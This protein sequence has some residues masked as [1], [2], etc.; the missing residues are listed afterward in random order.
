MFPYFLLISLLSSGILNSR[1]SQMCGRLY[2]PIFLLSVGLFTLNIDG[3]FNCSGQA[4]VLPSYYLEVIYWCCMATGTL[5]LEYWGWGLQMFFISF[6]KRSSWLPYIFLPTV[7]TSTGVAINNTVLVGDFFFIFWW[8][9]DVFK[10]P[11]SLKMHVYSMSSTNLLQAFPHT[12][13]IWYYYMALGVMCTSWG[14]LFLFI[15]VFL[16]YLLY[17]LICSTTSE[18]YQCSKTSVQYRQ[19][20]SLPTYAQ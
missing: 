4:I 16:K 1:L 2:F 19:L 6:S 8:H 20:T 12:F 15:L 3:F 17:S 18:H 10:C 14:L 11:A 9:Q 7:N 5:V 13:H